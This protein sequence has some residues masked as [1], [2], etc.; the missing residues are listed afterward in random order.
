MWLLDLRCDFC[1]SETR[2][3]EPFCDPA[4]IGS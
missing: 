2:S 3:F 4:G 1:G